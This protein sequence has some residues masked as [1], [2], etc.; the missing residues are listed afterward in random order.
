MTTCSD[1]CSEMEAGT[2]RLPQA[3]LPSLLSKPSKVRVLKQLTMCYLSYDSMIG[4]CLGGSGLVWAQLLV[5]WD[6]SL[7]H[8]VSILPESPH[9]QSCSHSALGS[10]R[11][12][13]D[14][15]L[16]SSTSATSCWP[17]P[18][19]RPAQMLG[20]VFQT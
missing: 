15:D 14:M 9:P 16:L 3:S 13:K 4:N 1:L 12:Q 7:L 19:L 10:E 17:K 2:Q 6:C 18:C 5:G 11:E 20:W 8:R